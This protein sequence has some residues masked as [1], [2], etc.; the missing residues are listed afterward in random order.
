MIRDYIGRNSQSLLRIF[1]A[2]DINKD[3]RVALPEFRKALENMDLA[4][5]SESQV[6][7]VVAPRKNAVENI[8]S[9]VDIFVQFCD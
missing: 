5:L 2:F 7:L 8:H 1:R 4:H 9:F 3:R 6:T